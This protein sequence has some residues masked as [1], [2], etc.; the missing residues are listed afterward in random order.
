MFAWVL[1]VLVLCPSTMLSEFTSLPRSAPSTLSSS[2]VLSPL[3]SSSSLLDSSLLVSCL[4]FPL[5]NSCELSVSDRYSFD[6]S[7]VSD[8]SDSEL[9]SSLAGSSR[10]SSSSLIFPSSLSLISSSLS[11]SSS[12]GCSVDSSSSSIVSSLTVSP[13]YRSL[14]SSPPSMVPTGVP[15][16][17]SKVGQPSRLNLLLL[18]LPPIHG[19]VQSHCLALPAQ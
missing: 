2:L 6:V 18:R 10:M 3:L 15:I 9:L 13:S 14:G 11:S 16:F 5:L 8:G 4:E 12:S 17:H 7:V 19:R 1:R